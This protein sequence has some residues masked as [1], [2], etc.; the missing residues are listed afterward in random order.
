VAQA[1]FAAGARLIDQSRFLEAVD[2]FNEG[3]RLRPGNALAHSYLGIA[4]ASLGRYR[5]ALASFDAALLLDP[6]QELAQR[7]RAQLLPLRG[8]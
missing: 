4:Q 6:Q 8:R 7:A 5:D 2:R 1:S 3:L